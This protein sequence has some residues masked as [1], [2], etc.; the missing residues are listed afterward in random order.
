M[1]FSPVPTRDWLTNENADNPARGLDRVSIASRTRG[2]GLDE[3][4]RFAGVFVCDFSVFACDRLSITQVFVE[5][6]HEPIH[7]IALMF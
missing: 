2:R 3:E 7:Q 1:R 4:T 6:G 5:P